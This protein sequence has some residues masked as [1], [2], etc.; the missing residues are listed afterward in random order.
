MREI[1]AEQIRAAVCELCRTANYELPDDVVASFHAA[2]EREQSPVGREILDQLLENAAIG[3]RERVPVCQDTGMA[4]VFLELGQDVH[5]TGGDLNEA[6]HDGVREGYTGGFLRNSV[7]NDPLRRQNTGD[8]A[9]AVIHVEIVPGDRV[10][11]TLLAKGFGAEIMS[12]LK[13]FVPSDGIE[14]VKRFVVDTVVEAG[15]NAC[16]PII[17][18]VGLGGTFEKVTYLAK[19]ALLRKVGEPHP[20][21]LVADLEQELLELVNA[22]GIGPQGLG[23]TV[24]ATAV[25]VETY[26][27]HIAA[28][29]VAVNLNCATPRHRTVVL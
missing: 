17:V 19:K 22:T 24:T 8:N 25:H 2:K 27:T 7:I 4:V 16:P 18:G 6:I 5:I 14:A 29:P 12:R 23:G 20:D 26:A 10:K 21:P 13:M 9:P 11:L 15:A 28:F 1:S 3:K